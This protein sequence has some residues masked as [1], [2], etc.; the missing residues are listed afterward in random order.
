[1]VA[2]GFPSN[3]L[4]QLSLRQLRELASQL[5]VG[6]Y[7]RLLKEQLVLA[8][9]SRASQDE[10]EPG[11]AILAAA[12][13]EPPSPGAQTPSPG[14]QAPS[15]GAQPLNSGSDAPSLQDLEAQ[16]PPAPRPV[17]ETRVVFLPR[18][19]QWAYVFWQIS[20]ADR[21]EALAGGGEQLALRVMD[22]T[23]RNGGTA[24]PHTLQ[25]V[26]VDGAAHEWYV[27]VPLS[28]RDY[29]VELGFRRTGGGWISLAISAAARMPSSEPVEAIADQFVPF[30]LDT[31]SN[32][33][34]S[35]AQP[36]VLP[37]AELHERLYQQ[38]SGGRR[39]L[40]RGSE[41]FQDQDARHQ[42][43]AGQQR[44][45][46]G[47]WASGRSDSGAGLAARQRDFWLVAD[48]EL[49]VYGATDPSAILQIGEEVVPLSPEGT[50]RVQVPFRDGEQ[51]YPITALAADREQQRSITLAFRRTTPEANTNSR[52]DSVAEWF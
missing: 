52:E 5:G 44:S 22:V 36:A 31:F 12:A 51:H 47:L 23:G 38:A 25:E 29:R 20:A 10:P 48:A 19:P 32:T 41:G 6:R 17:G 43:A 37:A 27:P 42:T 1:M 34:T 18:D 11:A 39:S 50:F 8:I 33:S 49:I 21:A 15:L 46:V 3:N 13:S 14:G 9:Q 40:G 45:G 26:V 24:H 4:A 16:L 2:S 7:S 35:P 30:S 28:D